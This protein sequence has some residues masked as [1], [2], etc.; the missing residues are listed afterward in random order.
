MLKF[1][2]K[3]NGMGRSKPAVTGDHSS[4]FAGKAESPLPSASARFV[5]LGWRRENSILIKNSTKEDFSI[6]W[7]WN[8]LGKL[9]SFLAQEQQK[10]RVVCE[11][12]FP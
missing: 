4:V 3:I 8:W 5:F 1:L 12:T 2:I 6:L 11:I 10:M 9:L 7:Q